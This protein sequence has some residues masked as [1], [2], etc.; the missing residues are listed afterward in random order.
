MNSLSTVHDHYALPESY[1]FTATKGAMAD[2]TTTDDDIAHDYRLVP[3]QHLWA[4]ALLGFIT[5]YA[6]RDGTD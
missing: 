1:Y 2:L 5:D 4:P 3:Y 6:T